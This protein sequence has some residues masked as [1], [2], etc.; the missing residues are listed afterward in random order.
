MEIILHSALIETPWKNGAGV[1]REIG[2]ELKDGRYIW[3]LSMA[4]VT[5]DGEF[6]NFSGLVRILTVI[7]G[8]GMKLIYE[9][10]TLLA[11]PCVPLRFDGNL[12][13]HA[14]LNSG[15]STN[16]NLMFDPKSCTGEV[17][18][19]S[20]PFLQTLKPT[21]ERTYA[22]HTLT[23]MAKF[24]TNVRLSPGDTLLLNSKA[25]QL[26]LSEGDTALLILVTHNA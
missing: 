7:A 15:P 4:D 11:N 8:H 21:P 18:S 12:K 14:R 16:L 6:S 20:G 1:T 13:I 3:R 22:V 25:G 17:T 19:L 23:G 5:R 2:S 9:D 24:D 26:N 10:N